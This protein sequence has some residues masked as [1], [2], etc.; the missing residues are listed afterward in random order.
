MG[1]GRGR[2]IHGEGDVYDGEWVNDKAHGRGTYLHMD[3]EDK[4]HGFGVE[5]WPDGGKYEGNFEYGKKHGM[6]TFKWADGSVYIGEF[7]NNLI[8]GKGV[9]TWADGREYDGEWCNG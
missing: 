8:H 6:G 5:T 9:Y 2:I 1:D 7:Y 4:Q 3:R